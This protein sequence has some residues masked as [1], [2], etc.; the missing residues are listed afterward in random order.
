MNDRG[1]GNEKST[2]K[3]A[4]CEKGKEER[5]GEGNTEG[6]GRGESRKR[7][8]CAAM[9]QAALVVMPC[10]DLPTPKLL[11]TSLQISLTRSRD[12]LL[13][14]TQERRHGA[15]RGVTSA[16]QKEGAGGGLGHS[17]RVAPQGRVRLV[18]CIAVR[19]DARP[20]NGTGMERGGNRG[21]T[22]RGGRG[23]VARSFSPKTMSLGFSST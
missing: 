3:G 21:R 1:K 10:E 22:L 4:D 11:P 17:S 6:E 12:P 14:R 9:K 2:R 19:T 16:R 8:I 5:K 15:A 7:R 20:Q 13:R 23:V 18:W